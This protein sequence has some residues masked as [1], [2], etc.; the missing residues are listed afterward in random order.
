MS[1]EW[2]RNLRTL[3]QIF[4]FAVTNLKWYLLFGSYF[5]YAKQLRFTNKS[6]L[7]THLLT[8]RSPWWVSWMALRLGSVREARLRITLALRTAF[9]NTQPFTLFISPINILKLTELCQS[10]MWPDIQKYPASYNATLPKKRREY[11]LPKSESPQV[12]QCWAWWTWFTRRT[13]PPSTSH[14]QPWRSPLKPAHPK[15]FQG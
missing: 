8:F 15:L 3:W 12:A 5:N 4:L 7:L 13:P 9:T 6:G 11:H 10:Y 14:S 2:P 1:H